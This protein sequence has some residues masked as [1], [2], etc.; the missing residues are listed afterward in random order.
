M[1]EAKNS[2]ELRLSSIEFSKSASPCSAQVVVINDQQQKHKRM[3]EPGLEDARK[4][5]FAM[6]PAAR[7]VAEKF[8]HVRDRDFAQLDA[9]GC[10][11]L[12]Y[13]GAMLA[14][15]SLV[16]RHT[17]MLKKSILGLCWPCVDAAV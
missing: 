5:Y 7:A 8:T 4:A 6:F 16:E 9:Q 12:D 10:V 11:Y 14:P 17:S 1:E 2:I 13:T 3:A 15:S